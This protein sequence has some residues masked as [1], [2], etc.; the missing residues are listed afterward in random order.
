[1]GLK[2]PSRRYYAFL[3]MESTTQKDL[4]HSLRSVLGLVDFA[5]AEITVEVYG[6]IFMVSCRREFLYRVRGA[7]ALKYQVKP[8]AVSGTRKGLQR[9]LAR[10]GIKIAVRKGKR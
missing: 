4:L 9:L 5:R 8:L 7:I 2:K 3:P 10:Q 6:Q 1:M